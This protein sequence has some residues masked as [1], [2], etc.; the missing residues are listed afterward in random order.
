MGALNIVESE[1]SGNASAF[2]GAIASVGAVE[3]SGS[4]FNANTAFGGGAIF[5]WG[6]GALTV[7]GSEFNDNSATIDRDMT[8]EFLDS[9]DDDERDLGAA[10]IVYNGY[11]GAIAVRRRWKSHQ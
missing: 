9:V 6:E 11:G 1:F 8:Q 2:G 7:T 5:N 10:L 4:E 3:I